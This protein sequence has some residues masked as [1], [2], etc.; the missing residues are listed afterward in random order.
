MKIHSA[1]LASS[2]AHYKVCPE[3]TKPEVAFIG[4]S[5]VGK[6]SL[7]NALLQRK[8]L[9]RVSKMPGKTQLI[10]HFLVNNQLY[11]V[12]LPGYGWAQVGHATKIKWKK[13]LREYLLHRSNMVAVFVL[14]DAKIAPQAIDIECINWLGQHAI[15]FAIILTKADKKHKMVAQKHHMALTRILQ[16]EWA[17]IP[18]LFMVSAHNRLGIENLLGYIQA[19][20]DPNRSL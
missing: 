5:N 13:M 9:A 1:A 16:Q 6:S 10:H 12:D 4:R 17:T 7:I 15:P 8:Q 20:T 18:P 2:N 11:F 19:V 14:I 3:D